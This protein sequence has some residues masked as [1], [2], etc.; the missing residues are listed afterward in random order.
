MADRVDVVAPV[1]GLVA[2]IA[3]ARG[4]AVAAG[5]TVVTLQS[6]KME[7]A[8]PSDRPGT[9]GGA[10]LAGGR[11]GDRARGRPGD[12]RG[13]PLR[14]RAGRASAPTGARSPPAG[15]G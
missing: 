1:P 10:R 3:V 11:R 12:G 5:D 13:S 7:I 4:A 6:M 14:C 2:S 9:G 8:V 15:A